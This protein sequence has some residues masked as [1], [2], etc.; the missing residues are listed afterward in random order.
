MTTT[1]A[2][3]PHIPTGTAAS[4]IPGV[5]FPDPEAI[6]LANGHLVAEGVDWPEASFEMYFGSVIGW[7]RFERNDAMPERTF[8]ATAVLPEGC[9]DPFRSASAQGV[10]W[11]RR[12]AIV[13]DRCIESFLAEAGRTR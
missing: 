6:V 13:A 2:A 10:W 7:V 5:T 12:A 9:R 1:P 3:L 11:R 8:R 4:T